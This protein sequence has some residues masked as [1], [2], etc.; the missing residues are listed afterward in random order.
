[1]KSRH[2]DFTAPNPETETKIG[3]LIGSMT[4]EE[5]CSMLGGG[6]GE[7]P[8]GIGGG[9]TTPC[10]RVGI[11]MFRMADGPVGVH[12]WTDAATAYPVSVAMAA[13][14]NTELAES[15]GVA[16]GR[17]CRARG[18][19]ILLGPG[20]NIY[21]SPLC[22]R[23]FEYLGEDPVLAGAIAAA[24]ID[25]L[26][27]QRV[28]ATVK[29]YALN[30]QEFDR[31]DV[32]SDVDERTLREVYLPAFEAAVRD[33]GSGAVM[34]GYNLVNGEHCSQNEH[35]N[36]RILKG[37]WGFDGILMSDWES[38][39]DAVGAVNGGLDL[40]MPC[41]RTVT[42]D[43]LKSAIENGLVSEATIDDK[44]RRILR[45]AFAFGWMDSEQKDDSIPQDD[46]ASA[47]VAL[48]LAREGCVLLKNEDLLPIEPAK[49]KKL[50]VIGH[51]A[52][53]AVPCG[54]GS[55]YTKSFHTTSVLEGLQQRLGDEVEIVHAE[56]Y[57][58][59][60]LNTVAPRKCWTKD[61]GTPGVLGEYWRGD[62]T[63]EPDHVYQQ[64]NMDV[65]WG[66]GVPVQ[67]KGFR[68]SF[69][70]RWTGNFTAVHD[71]PHRVYINTSG[72]VRLCVDGELLAS[73][74]ATRNSGRYFETSIDLKA[75]Q[76][77]RFVVEAQIPDWMWNMLQ[78]GIAAEREWQEMANEAVAAAEDADLVVFCAGFSTSCETETADRSFELPAGQ[79]ELIQRIAACNPKLAV[80]LMSGGGVD[81][82]GWLEAVPALLQIWYPGQDGGTAIA[83]ILTG[84]VSPSGKLPMT[85]DQ[86]L[87]QRS[88]F[89]NYH[90]D[91]GDKR[92]RITD[93]VFTGYRHNDRHQ[94]EPAFPFGF[95]LSY[96]SFRIG[97]PRVSRDAVTTDDELI[98]TVDVTNTG[99]RAA[100]EVVQLY[101]SD[102]EASVPRPPKELKGFTKVYLQPGE[103]KAV[104]IKLDHRAWRYW[105]LQKSA[106]TVEPGTFELLFGNSSNRIACRC[107]VTVSDA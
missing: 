89:D 76:R 23:N 30:Y 56:G 63:G 33:A 69:S 54:G 87:A 22:G 103:Q 77:Y 38:T 78:I 11:P 45:L 94:I 74:A 70:T 43:A 46:P 88:S 32:S 102:V 72:E 100:A 66:G 47:E 13:S 14:W 99:G 101:V 68:R 96:S 81:L 106:W 91:D 15:F 79:A 59:V 2:P 26:Q 5:K 8:W 75:G 34:A 95:G 51:S 12:W 9:G 71:G 25:G 28:A 107:T 57:D 84:D 61:D 62:M 39:Y 50:A 44:I 83:E 36:N 18:V 1:M 16:I 85:F 10:E 31:H 97:N 48:D 27:S 92:V 17:D 55:A 93:G 65:L 19:H 29:H 86:S 42:H 64:D 40:E 7:A 67:D 58:P 82:N 98:A 37:E 20:V 80:L 24:A 90:D 4:F 53:P 35:L 6:K 60:Q 21:R 41:I 3:R 73:R 104:T 49:L 105:D 52:H